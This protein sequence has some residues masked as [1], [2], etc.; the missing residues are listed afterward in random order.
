[1]RVAGQ[2]PWRRR[3]PPFRRGAAR[4]AP[5]RRDQQPWRHRGASFRTGARGQHRSPAMA[6]AAGRRRQAC[7]RGKCRPGSSRG[8]SSSSSLSLVMAA[9]LGSSDPS[10]DHNYGGDSRWERRA[11]GW[12]TGATPRVRHHTP[13]SL[14]CP[15]QRRHR[16][17]G[18]GARWPR[19]QLVQEHLDLASASLEL[20][21][22]GLRRCWSA[23][24][25]PSWARPA[26]ATAAGRL[27][28]WQRERER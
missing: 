17:H 20:A 10:V 9:G 6:V 25:L 2:Q 22:D 15:H 23:R 7:G 3:G 18:H 14:P 5:F 27:A 26:S 11:R 1:M 21:A 28:G 24:L 16:R 8:R 13:R 19:G 4:G 12:S